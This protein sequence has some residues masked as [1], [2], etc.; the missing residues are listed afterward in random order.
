MLADLSAKDPQ[1]SSSVQV[2]RI[3]RKA[4]EPPLSSLVIQDAFESR[5]KKKRSIVGASRG[6]FRLAETVPD[7]WEGSGMEGEVLKTR[8]KDLLS[9]PTLLP[10][11]SPHQG[12]SNAAPSASGP[13]PSTPAKRKV[14][15]G[16]PLP[17]T[18]T[19]Y[20]VIP[21]PTKRS[22]PQV[23]LPPRVLTLEEL[24]RAESGLSFIDAQA[25]STSPRAKPYHPSD[26]PTAAQEAEM[27]S[28]LPMLTEYLKCG[29]PPSK[30]HVQP[31]TRIPVDRERQDSI[32]LPDTVPLDSTLEEYV[33]DLYYRDVRPEALSGV[34]ALG[35][36]AGD[37]V[38]VGIG[39]L[40]GYGDITP[41]SSPSES[42]AEDEADED[43]NREDYYGADYPED[44]DADE[45]MEGFRGAYSDGGWSEEDELEREEEERGNWEYR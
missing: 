32:P 45:D 20:R 18:A 11:P 39:A 8:I 29:V 16:P 10:A 42:E 44:E 43:E 27:A 19:Q 31:L 23:M 7:T 33:Y 3:K 14:S 17:P 1:A 22:K 6:V 24:K 21:P 40:L 36:G 25:V 15:A 12:S 2:L 35:L 34:A 30:H 4:T 13:S 26:S 41:P 37:G 38:G 28:F 9:A 5:I